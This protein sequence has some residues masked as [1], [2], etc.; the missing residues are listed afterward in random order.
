MLLGVQ[1]RTH[2]NALG[3]SVTRRAAAA[4]QD[5]HPFALAIDRHRDDRGVNSARARL[6]R[7]HRMYLSS[8]PSGASQDRFLSGNFLALKSG[9]EN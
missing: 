1:Q 8:D 5:P 9:G 3:Q 7:N 2:V 4:R 6:A